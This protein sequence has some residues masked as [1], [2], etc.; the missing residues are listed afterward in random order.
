MSKGKKSPGRTSSVEK[1][2]L[3]KMGYLRIPSSMLPTDARKKGLYLVL[4]GIDRDAKTIF[5]KPTYAEDLVDGSWARKASYP[6]D[7]A[8]SPIVPVKPLLEVL[9]VAIPE[10]AVL[11]DSRKR[12][13]TLEVK[14]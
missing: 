12:S 9:G 1:M 3:N 7:A 6:N 8:L 11:V 5:L 14:F 4:A 2:V 13:D 10:D